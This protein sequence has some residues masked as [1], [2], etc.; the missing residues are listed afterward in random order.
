MKQVTI[1]SR[2]LKPLLLLSSQDTSAKGSAHP[3]GGDLFVHLQ[4][5]LLAPCCQLLSC[6]AYLHLQK[7]NV[8]TQSESHR[9]N[10]GS[11]RNLHVTCCTAV[12]C[13]VCLLLLGLVLR[14]DAGNSHVQS[15]P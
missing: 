10:S 15:Y 11:G 8:S 3:Q 13:M 2:E 4:G 7:V 12:L 1:V 14:N 5:M 9:Q 6:T